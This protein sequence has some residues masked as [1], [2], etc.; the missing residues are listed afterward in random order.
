MILPLGDYRYEYRRAGAVIATE[1]ARFD[2]NRIVGERRMADSSNRY[3]VDA[4]LSA[5]GGIIR[6][7]LGYERGPFTRAAA[8][9]ASGDMLRGQVSAMVGRNEVAAKLGRFREIDADLMLMRALIIAHVRARGGLRWTG[10]VAVID[11]A[12][13]VPASIKQSAR[14]IDESGRKWIYEARMGDREQ[15]E[16]DAEGTILRRRDDRGV[17]TILMPGPPA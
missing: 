10:R 1:Q 9:V 16:I 14:P 6:I 8:Y 15:I 2:G 12:T 7:N 3:H 17:E 13:L 4:E 5:E 11:P